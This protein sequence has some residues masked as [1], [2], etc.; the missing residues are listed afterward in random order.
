MAL[1]I[2]GVFSRLACVKVRVGRNRPLGTAPIAVRELTLRAS[3]GSLEPIAPVILRSRPRFPVLHQIHSRTAV[4]TIRRYRSARRK[5]AGGRRHGLR[6]S[7]RRTSSA[8]PPATTRHRRLGTTLIADSH[9]ARSPEVGSTGEVSMQHVSD[10]LRQ[11]NRFL[12][13]HIRI[14]P[15]TETTAVV[16]NAAIFVRG[17]ALRSRRIPATR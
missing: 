3:G 1:T 11:R 7:K 16:S 9:S 17:W 12:P 14:P 2:I 6:T 5:F 13:K 10:Q 8:W 15:S 4:H